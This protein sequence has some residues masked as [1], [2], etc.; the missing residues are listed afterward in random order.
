MSKKWKSLTRAFFKQFLEY[1]F[2][3]EE[4]ISR[5]WAYLAHNIYLEPNG[6]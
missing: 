3:I 1:I 6:A 5:R 4:L 2:E